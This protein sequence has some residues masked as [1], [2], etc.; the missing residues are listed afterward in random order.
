MLNLCLGYKRGDDGKLAIDE[1]DAEIVRKMFEMRAGGYNLGA[2]PNWLY[3]NK[4]PSPTGKP[5]WSWE[6]I[7]KL[8]R[9]EKYVGDV[10]FQKRAWRISWETAFHGI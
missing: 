3:E 7:S 5:L 8:L 9:N 10:L 1:P 4:I 6:T 2:I